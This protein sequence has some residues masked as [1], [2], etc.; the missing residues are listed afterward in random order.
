M[1]KINFSN[2]RFSQFPR[3]W[4]IITIPENFICYRAGTKNPVLGNNPRFFSEYNIAK[5][6]ADEDNYYKIYA[7]IIN[8][9]KLVDLR[10]LRYLFIEYIGYNDLLFSEEELENINLTKFALGLMS[11]NDQHIFMTQNLQKYPGLDFWISK[12]DTF[13]D[14]LYDIECEK[15]INN[16]SSQ[17]D[18]D[19]NE[20]LY[21]SFG[22]R[23]SDCAIDDK[24]VAFLK[25][26]FSDTIDGY[27]SPHINSVWH[28]FNFPP[29]L[30]LFTPNISLKKCGEVLDNNLKII[31]E[32]DV[33]ISVLLNVTYPLPKI[34]QKDYIKGG[35]TQTCLLKTSDKYKEEQEKIKKIPKNFL[36]EKTL[37]NSNKNTVK[38]G[39][40]YS[41]SSNSS[42]SNSDSNSNSNSSND[43]SSVKY[44]DNLFQKTNS[45][46]NKKNVDNLNQNNNRNNLPTNI[47]KPK[48][49]TS[50]EYGLTPLL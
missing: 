43:N 7:C 5:L 48:F 18:I 9:L 29:E 45:N 21:S 12:Y 42:N 27:I 34:A 39:N 6:Y 3:V 46:S 23:I 14:V 49:N 10:T 11:L 40:L 44:I 16:D 28:G 19:K 47:L 38:Y 4:G 1:K 13:A 20:K 8:E 33:D 35:G 32:P 31:N 15:N 41:N 30:C 24:V 37:T 25:N 2:L 22:Q 36:Y 26:I 50:D 17:F